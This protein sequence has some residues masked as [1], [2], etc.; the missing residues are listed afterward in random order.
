[1]RNYDCK[2]HIWVTVAMKGMS[3]N[4]IERVHCNGTSP[5]AEAIDRVCDCLLLLVKEKGGKRL[6]FRI[7]FKTTHFNSSVK[8]L[9]IRES[10]Y[11]A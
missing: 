4:I 5:L 2:R 9:G 8:I 10:N 1:M 3:S 11:Q 7:M 6:R